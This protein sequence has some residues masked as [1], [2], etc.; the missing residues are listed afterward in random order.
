M[1]R[2]PTLRARLR[3]QVLAS[4]LAEATRFPLCQ[5]AALE[6]LFVSAG[7]GQVHGSAITI[8][9][10]FRDFHDLWSPFL[11]GQ[12]PAPTYAM[13]LPERDRIA[14]REHFRQIVPIDADG[15]IALSAKA[16]IAR[17]VRV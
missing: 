9:T 14:L 6:Q 12:G 8:S 7:A 5:P 1:R 17:G 2:H 15:S 3:I 16:W 10:R 4:A 11:G 13:S